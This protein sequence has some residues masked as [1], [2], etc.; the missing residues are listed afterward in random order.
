MDDRLCD[1]PVCVFWN[2]EGVCT[3]PDNVLIECTY[4]ELNKPLR[5]MAFS[6][7]KGWERY[8]EFLAKPV[9]HEMVEAKIPPIDKNIKF[10]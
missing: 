3:A 8:Q 2:D 4:R 1:N 9:K 10:I 6:I 5:E 7:Q